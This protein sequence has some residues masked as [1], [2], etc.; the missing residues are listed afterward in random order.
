MTRNLDSDYTIFGKLPDRFA[1]KGCFT[2][3]PSGALDEQKIA[4]FFLDPYQNSAVL[5]AP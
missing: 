5:L 4:V 1:R 2:G 3:F